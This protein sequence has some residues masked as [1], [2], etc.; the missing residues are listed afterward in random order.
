M[1]RARNLTFNSFNPLG[2]SAYPRPP[3]RPAHL[4]PHLH[5]AGRAD[6]NTWSESELDSHREP[7]DA[8]VDT[9]A[10]NT[11]TAR[12][13]GPDNNSKSVLLL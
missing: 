4:A 10:T 11:A 8:T 1:E 6:G 12:G 5:S 7:M 13:R 9:T 2:L 3:P